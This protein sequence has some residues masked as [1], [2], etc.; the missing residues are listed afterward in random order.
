MSPIR[1]GNYKKILI[2]KKMKI[3]NTF[4]NFREFPSLTSIA[5]HFGVSRTTIKKILTESVDKG[6]ISENNHL[7]KRTRKDIVAVKVRLIQRKINIVN[8]VIKESHVKRA[9]SVNLLQKKFGG[10]KKTI[11]QILKEVEKRLVKTKNPVIRRTKS[12][13]PKRKI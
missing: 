13:Q 9:I 6:L 10:E 11:G 8:F 2:A 4:T 7:L 1:K 3:T 12:S 5:N